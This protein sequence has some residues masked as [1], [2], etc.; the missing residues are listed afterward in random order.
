[1]ATPIIL[2]GKQVGRLRAS[3]LLFKESWRFLSLDREMLWV[4]PITVLLNLFLLGIILGVVFLL[5]SANGSAVSDAD[6][7]SGFGYLILFLCY[8]AGAF[9]LALGQAAIV[10]T[11]YTRMHGGNATLKQSLKV[12]FSHAGSLFLWSCITSTVGVVLQFLSNQGKGVGLIVSKII[13]ALLGATWS[14]LT[15][16]VV[17]AMVVDRKS[18]FASIPRSA[19]VFK[20]TWGETLVGNFSLGAVFFLAHLLVLLS[21]IG[22]SVVTL[23]M[24]NIPLFIALCVLVVIWLVVSSIVHSTLNAVLRTLLYIYATENVVPQ[25]FNPELLSAMLQKRVNS[26][27]PA[28]FPPPPSAQ[29]AE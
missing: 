29:V 19:S 3:W 7:P 10:H 26:Y 20:H 4:S 24:R 8:V 11:V 28:V 23:S 16:F 13:A 27:A 22:L 21:F 12:A 25:N 14:I 5:L 17:P 1:M 18:A 2:E 15:Y 6:V 9:S